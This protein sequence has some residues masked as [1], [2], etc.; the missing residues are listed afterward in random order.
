MELERLFDFAIAHDVEVTFH[1]LTFSRK[2]G[3][4]FPDFNAI[5]LL[6]GM[7]EINTRCT[8]AH[9][10]GHWA[11]GHCGCGGK[12]ELQADRWAARLL[13]SPLEFEVA[14][15]QF[16]GHAGAIAEALG[17]TRHMVEVYWH[18][19]QCARYRIG[20]AA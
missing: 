16:D 20:L 9:E 13:I 4:W 6:E 12:E 7:G 19:T 15:E 14:A 8:L 17:V 5:S 18:W 2:K 1:D 10:L 3:L 11:K